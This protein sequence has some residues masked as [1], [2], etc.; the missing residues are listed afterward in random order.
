MGLEEYQ[1]RAQEE[2]RERKEFSASL[3]DGTEPT[4]DGVKGGQGRDSAATRDSAVGC[5]WMVVTAWVMAIIWAL[6]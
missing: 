1:R 5:G 6:T 3:G 2:R 4:P